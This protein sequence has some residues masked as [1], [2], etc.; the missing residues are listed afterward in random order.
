M[1]RK[2]AIKDPHADREAQKYENPIPSREYILE[3]LDQRGKPATHEELCQE[4]LLLDEES[5]EALRRRLIAMSRDGQLISNRRGLFG[6]VEKMNLVRGTVQGNKEGFG[7][8]L[9]DDGSADL[10]LN[11]NQMRKAFD[12]DKVLA[13]VGGLDRRGRREGVIVEVLEHKS[14]ILVGR[15]YR[16]AGVGIV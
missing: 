10:F 14:D 3:H 12:G 2:K 16:E 13:R 15:Y 5:Q 8:L 1:S 11:P 6:L 7:F 4:L 9:P